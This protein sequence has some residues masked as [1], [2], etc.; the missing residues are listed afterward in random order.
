MVC[1]LIFWSSNV[2]CRVSVQDL[3]NRVGVK[4]GDVIAVEGIARIIS[5]LVE[6]DGT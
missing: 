5:F 3:L 6:G 1:Y 2:I 4:H